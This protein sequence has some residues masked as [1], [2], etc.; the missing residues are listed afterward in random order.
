MKRTSIFIIENQSSPIT[1]KNNPLIKRFR[2]F[3]DKLPTKETDSFC[4]EGTHL[5]EESIKAGLIPFNIFLPFILR[6]WEL[7]FDLFLL[8][9]IIHWEI[10]VLIMTNYQCEVHP[11]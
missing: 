10:V 5:L 1:S 11:S 3:K 9:Q 2:S 8:S 4:I 7:R 6:F